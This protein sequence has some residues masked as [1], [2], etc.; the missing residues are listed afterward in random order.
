MVKKY[1]EYIKEENE[2]DKL[3]ELS[4]DIELIE[5]DGEEEF[6]IKEFEIDS[7]IDIIVPEDREF[8]NSIELSEAVTTHVSPGGGK[9]YK[10]GQTIYI[11][12]LLRKKGTTSFNSPAVQGVLK[13]RIT[14]IFFGLQYLNKVIN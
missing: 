2:S 1:S 11:T 5:V 12:A 4:N 13:L 10:R 3:S 9:E 7:I 6:D 8:G 14:D